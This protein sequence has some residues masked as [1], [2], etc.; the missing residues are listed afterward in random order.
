MGNKGLM[1]LGKGKVRRKLCEMRMLREVGIVER[2]ALKVDSTERR[3]GT[4]RSTE[5]WE[6]VT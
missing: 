5:R 1:E 3:Y 2:E 4:G 6:R